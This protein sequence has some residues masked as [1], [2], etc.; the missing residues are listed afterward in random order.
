MAKTLPG[1]LIAK[2]GSA[3]SSWS[4]LNTF[5]SWDRVPL[6]SRLITNVTANWLNMKLWA[7]SMAL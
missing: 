4:V 1:V 5:H 6:R 2:R 3:V 7:D